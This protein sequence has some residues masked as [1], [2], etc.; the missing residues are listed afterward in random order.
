MSLALSLFSKK[1]PLVTSLSFSS[2]TFLGPIVEELLED[3][4]VLGAAVE[5]A[6]SFCLFPGGS[7]KGT[8]AADG[9]FCIGALSA[10]AADRSFPVS[11][12]VLPM[13]SSGAPPGG[14]AIRILGL[15]GSARFCVQQLPRLDSQI[16]MCCFD[17][18]PVADVGAKHLAAILARHKHLGENLATFGSKHLG[19]K[20]CKA[21][22]GKMGSS[23][24]YPYT[25]FLWN[26]EWWTKFEGYFYRF[27]LMLKT[28]AQI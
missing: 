9:L 1:K 13:A 7:T 10:G 3:A 28:I 15:L 12:L 4:D 2:P 18:C 23:A 19:A 8:T 21:K 27:G 25:W 26:G 22:G 6:A 16:L 14:S 20:P 24:E 5:P 17:E 11:G